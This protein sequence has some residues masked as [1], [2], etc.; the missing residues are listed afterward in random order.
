MS[1]NEQRILVVDD[2]VDIIEQTRLCL[3][4]AGYAVIAAESE[5]EAERLIEEGG[6]DLAILDLMM[7]HVDAGFILSHK[8]RRRHPHVPII[9]I[10]SV[11]RETGF[12][13]GAETEE[14]RDWI[15]A[16]LIIQKDVRPEQL[17][18]EVRRLLR[19]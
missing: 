17:V 12:R 6:F 13:F 15:N 18:G 2:D 14:E 19:G 3:T 8:L 7:E 5:A 16:D 11:T 9:I 1:K 10:T 4:Q